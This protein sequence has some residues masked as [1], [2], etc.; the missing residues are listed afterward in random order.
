[1]QI[2]FSK[3]ISTLS[4]I[5]LT[6]FTI[7][8]FAY[9]TTYNNDIFILIFCISLSTALM[10]E[11]ILLLGTLAIV[12][13][14]IAALFVKN[15]HYRICAVW[16]ILLVLF[17]YFIPSKHVNA[18]TQETYYEANK[19]KLWEIAHKVDNI[20]AKK[21]NKFPIRKDNKY[22]DLFKEGGLTEEDFLKIQAIIKTEDIEEIRYYDSVCYIGHQYQALS[23]YGYKLGLH[24]KKLKD[25]VTC[26][27]YN[28]SVSFDY[29]SG[30]FGEIGYPNKDKY[31]EEKRKTK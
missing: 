17:L 31:L 4:Y 1:M 3:V 26:I 13:S 9:T 16:S 28:D 7:F 12:Y 10:P 29:C 5:S 19:D 2:P 15:K 24:N 14:C 23:L 18:W 21:A 27:I 30:A 22:E 11:I 6:I 25:D 8:G 20:C